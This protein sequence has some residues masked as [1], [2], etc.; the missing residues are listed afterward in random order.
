MNA[1]ERSRAWL[2]LFRLDVVPTAAGLPLAGFLTTF[3]GSPND[4]VPVFRLTSICV[5]MF[6]AFAFGSVA[7]DL[8]NM[9]LDARVEPSRPIPS[10]AVGAKGAT[11]ASLGAILFALIPAGIA[12]ELLSCAAAVLAAWYVSAFHLPPTKAGG[13]LL[14]SI[15]P[16]L[17]FLSGA[18]C[19]SF[20]SVDAASAARASLFAAGLFLASW[21]LARLNAEKSVFLKK[22]PGGLLVLI[23]SFLCYCV[24]FAMV[25]ATPF[26]GFSAIACGL[27]AA[28]SGGFFLIAAFFLARFAK[29]G[30]PPAMM[31]PALLISARF[32]FL[33]EAAVAAS[34]GL[35]SAALG[36][37]AACGVLFALGRF[38]GGM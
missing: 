26:R 3:S 14:I 29:A 20:R 10:G 18:F 16:P 11:L 36:L 23:G 24:V 2:R 12:L 30:A 7:R 15:L 19:V 25:A 38:S 32:L 35:P 21:G 9:N 33:A 31:H 5:S 22:R 4:P 1:T 8:A 27:L 37:I 28:V 13:R 17:A 6:F 34:A